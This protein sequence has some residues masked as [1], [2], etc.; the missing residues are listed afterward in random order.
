[1]PKQRDKWTTSP[2]DIQDG[3]RCAIKV[4]GVAG[5]DNDWAAYWGPTEWSDEQVAESGVKL[6]KEEAE[7]LGYLFQLRCY[8]R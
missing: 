8:R 6:T 2:S 3:D 1:M 7:V 5:Y 4:V